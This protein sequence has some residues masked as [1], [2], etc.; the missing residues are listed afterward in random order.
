MPSVHPVPPSDVPTVKIKLPK[1]G[2][3][4]DSRVI[5]WDKHVLLYD[6][7]YDSSRFVYKRKALRFECKINGDI[8]TVARIDYKGAVGWRKTLYFRIYDPSVE[9]VPESFDSKTYRYHGLEYEMV[10]SDAEEVVIDDSVTVVRYGAFADRKT[11]KMCITMGDNVER[12]EGQC[13]SMEHL[14][15]SRGLRRF[16]GL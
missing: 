10:P 5:L 8:L 4:V 1:E 3:V 14:E 11:L 2:L 12:I 13:Y 7:R 9:Q 6:S 15:L 16:V